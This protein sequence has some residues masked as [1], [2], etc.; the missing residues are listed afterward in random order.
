MDPFPSVARIYSLVR[1]EEKQQEIHTLSN[2]VP[3]AAALNFQRQNYRQSQPHNSGKF[4]KE[5]ASNQPFNNKPQGPTHQ[6]GKLSP[7]CDH[8][9][10]VGHYKETCYKIHGYPPKNFHANA[11]SAVIAPHSAANA[12]HSAAPLTFTMD[13]YS[14]LLS[15]RIAEFS[16]EQNINLA[17]NDGSR[18]GSWVRTKDEITQI[19]TGMQQAWSTHSPH[20]TE[21]GLQAWRSETCWALVHCLVHREARHGSRLPPQPLQGSSPSATKSAK[22][23][24][25]FT[26]VQNQSLGVQNRSS[27]PAWCYDGVKPCENDAA[28]KERAI[29]IIVRAHNEIKLIEFKP[30]II[31]ASALLLSSHELFPLQFSAFKASISSCEYEK[32]LKCFDTMQEMVEMEEGFDSMS[33]SMSS[34]TRTPVSVLDYKCSSKSSV[35]QRTTTTTAVMLLIQATCDGGLHMFVVHGGHLQLLQY[36]SFRLLFGCSLDVSLFLATVFALP[37]IYAKRLQAIWSLFINLMSRLHPSS[38]GQLSSSSS[39]DDLE[40]QQPVTPPVEQNQRQFWLQWRNIVMAFCFTSALE[41][42]LLFAQTKS[43][44]PLS[45]YILSLAILLTFLCLF[46]ANFI[47]PHFTNTA[48]VLE[49]IAALLF[50]TT[51][52]FT[53]AI[54]LPLILKC[55]IWALYAIALFAV[56]LLRT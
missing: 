33:M 32:L 3:E 4:G 7:Y 29:E 37:F 28:L 19:S 35:S 39:A 6:N 12:P 26:G 43:Q 56:L 51:V 5:Q 14:K 38:S 55:V 15:G 41:I 49:K 30:S 47:G 23:G 36:S 10:T 11:I 42:A 16:M 21:S 50:A 1:Q 9:K 20:C 18:R 31:A 46:V 24:G 27:S 17:A 52:V 54:P 53:I 2:T 48:Q 22:D 44:L 8:C 40:A 13:Q 25:S 34:S 45:F